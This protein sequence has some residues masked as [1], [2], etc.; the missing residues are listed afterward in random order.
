MPTLLLTQLDPRVLAADLD[1]RAFSL[2]FAQPVP[3]KEL[4]LLLVRGTSLSVIPGPDVEGSFVGDLKNVT[5]RQALDLV[6]P[7]LGLDFSVDGAVVRVFGR[8][9]ET[10]L[11]DISYIAT[12]RKGE[13]TVGGGAG[14]TFTRVS[15][16]T[17]GD[18]YADITKG[19]QGLV[20]D[21]ATFNV[22]RKAGL[23]QVTDF[24][25]RLDRVARYV[26]AVTDR[27]HRQVQID[28]RV[29]EI[30]LN[31]DHASGLDWTLLSRTRDSSKLLAALAAQGKVSVL[32]N[33]HLLAL[34]NEPA[35]VRAVTESGGGN[36]PRQTDSVTIGVT[37]HIAADG[38]V[39]LSVS[40][41]VSSE[42]RVPGESATREAQT[43]ARL[44][45]GESIVF[46]GFPR[47]R[48]S[49]ERKY[50]GAKG[51][52]FGRSTVSTKQRIEVVVLLTP[53]IVGW[54]SS[55]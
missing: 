10:R 17:D 4:L 41:I 16:T 25:E 28:A 2:T 43:L 14:A 42:G 30:E 51:G 34:N 31:A 32:A 26:D 27:I 47:E 7:P 38:G 35:I 50:A 21:T 18:L 5:V 46:G 39:M 15:A 52:W 24:P 36:D 23:L 44:A 53:R 13:S 9:Q 12:E 19:L 37:A 40:P 33:P 54:G 29:L 3:I 45:D 49:R 1:N 22:D 48:E 8:Q 55:E 11:F 6:L 20:S